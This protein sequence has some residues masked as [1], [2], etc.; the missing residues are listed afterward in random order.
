MEVVLESVDLD[1]DVVVVADLSVADVSVVLDVVVVSSFVVA[2]VVSLVVTSVVDAGSFPVVS[3]AKDICAN[4][5]TA[6]RNKSHVKER[7]RRALRRPAARRFIA[8]TV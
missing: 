8:E 2:V 7:W 6:M 5:R 1:S 4:I 3:W